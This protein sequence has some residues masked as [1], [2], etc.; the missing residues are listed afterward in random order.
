MARFLL[1]LLIAFGIWA[2]VTNE[3]DPDR[4]RTISDVDISHNGLA[5][6]L[7]IVEALPNTSVTLK[8]PQSVI[9]RIDD[10]DVLATVDLSN[11]DA[12]GTVESPVEITA[13]DG[14]RDVSAEPDTVSI[15]VD[16]VITEQFDITIVQPS[17]APATLT[18]ISLSSPSVTLRGVRQNVED[19]QRVE[20]RVQ[21]SGRTE[22]FSYTAQ[23]IPIGAN[24]QEV[25][26]TVQVE[27]VTV[28][29]SVEFEVG[30]RSVPVIVQCACPD[31]GGG[32]E[33]RDLLTATAIPPTVR[34]EGPQPLLDSVT[35]IRTVPISVENVEVTGFVG[36]ASGA[37]ELDT[38][39]LP[40]DVTVDR[41]SVN[42]YVQVEQTVQEFT[43][44]R[45]EI[46]NQSPNMSV[47]IDP[48]TVS[49]EVEGSAEALAALENDPPVAVIDLAGYEEGTVVVQ[50]RIIV[51]P[52]V[53][54][55]NL[56][57][58]NVEITIKR[59]PPA[60][61]ATPN[62]ER[63][64]SSEPAQSDHVTTPVFSDTIQ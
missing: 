43:Q 45:V 25:V 36:G 16:S 60:P 24:G 62:A 51:P 47:D 17:N 30:S 55:V 49:F 29:V 33:V 59:I 13:P 37:V 39:D 7:Q 61:T 56:E 31:E 26:D 50:P 53:R 27:P 40:A 14:L 38:S 63:N 6:N 10:S 34:I 35:A 9:Q 5:S 15:E 58:G 46:V 57:P 3:R 52:D 12:P 2:F 28:Q 48:G 32:I 22:S 20:V 8:G 23:P 11:V 4:T 54:V 64:T 18:E 19:I 41:P 44:Q 42:V 21:L 1:S